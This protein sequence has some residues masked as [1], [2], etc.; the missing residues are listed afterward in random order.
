MV[1][2]Q[3]EYLK[4]FFVL[5][6]LAPLWLFYFFS[7]RDARKRLGPGSPLH[8]ISHLGSLWRDGTRY[9]LVN[10]SLAAL[11]LALAHPQLVREK[12]VPQPEKID[13]VLLLDVSPSMR[14]EDIPPS[15]L[16]RSLEI[17]SQFARKKPPQ[18]RVGLV[19]FAS[20]SLILSYLTEDP[21]NILYYLDYLK[22][23]SSFSPGTNIGRA[24]RSGLTIIS[25]DSE[26]YPELTRHK[27]V[28][29]LISDGEDHGDEL[30]SAVRE[31]TR[32]GIR[33]HT[34]GIG[35]EEGAPIPIAREHGVVRYAEDSM[36]NRVLTRF[37]ERTLR[38]IAEVTGG[39]A[40]RS[41]T[42]QELG[43][44]FDGIVKQERNI[45][46]FRRIVEY[47][48]AYREFLLAAFGLLLVGMLV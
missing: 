42:G 24:I 48:D 30:E 12:R 14:A 21:F 27:K 13:V 33:I 15:R 46:G 28:F 37:D 31:A 17:V 34:I 41:L 29:I 44:F 3:P 9:L 39:S 10:M 32:R 2:L 19:S 25:R 18:D 23:D 47:Q 8:K 20:G 43:G 4:F 22:D 1:F 5:A 38:W 7:K 26:L 36:G 11:V 16:E 35:S 40:Y 45:E 6:L